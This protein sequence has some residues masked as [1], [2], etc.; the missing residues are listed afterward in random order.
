M[1]ENLYTGPNYIASL[2]VLSDALVHKA[3]ACNTAD[4]RGIEPP[5]EVYQR[6]KSA[7]I[8]TSPCFHMY[9]PRTNL[10]Y[11]QPD[12]LQTLVA[13]PVMLVFHM[14]KSQANLVYLHV[15]AL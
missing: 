8:P 4:Q 10:E 3:T 15:N 5:L 9:K 1:N 12:S 6:H 11:I 13:K 14:C 2:S 7:P